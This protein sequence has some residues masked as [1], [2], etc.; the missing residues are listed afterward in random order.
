VLGGVPLSLDRSTVATSGD[1]VYD[2]A[3]DAVVSGPGSAPRPGPLTITKESEQAMA[4][5][6]I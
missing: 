6:C 1:P 5:F 2:Q 4:G 3:V